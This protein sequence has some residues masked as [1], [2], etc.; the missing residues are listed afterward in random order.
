[1][2]LLKAKICNRI[3]KKYGIWRRIGLLTFTAL[4][5]QNFLGY[6]AKGL[7]LLQH[8]ITQLLS[9][10]RASC[11]KF[12]NRP[13]RCWISLVFSQSRHSMLTFAHGVLLY[14][15]IYWPVGVHRGSA[16][17]RPV[18]QVMR[19]DI[20]SLSGKIRRERI[21]LMRTMMTLMSHL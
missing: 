15:A 6:T 8:R 21:S 13:K 5:N 2:L 9:L 20:Q 4:F 12:N 19:G 7:V 3:L 17:S 1:M 18:I 11:V 14:W 16:P 10:F